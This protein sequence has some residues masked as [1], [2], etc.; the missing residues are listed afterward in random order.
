MNA[1]LYYSNTGESKRIAEHLAKQIGCEPIDITAAAD[2]EYHCA[3]LVFPVHCQNIPQKVASFLLR[4]KTKYLIVIATYGKMSYGNVL[5]EIQRRYRHNIIAAAYAPTKHAYVD[6]APFDK[7]EKLSPLLDKLTSPTTVNIPQ[8]RKNPFANLAPSWRSRQGVK[9]LLGEQCNGC[10]LCSA[11]CPEHAIK[12]GKTNNRCIRCLRCVGACPNKA[13]TFKL[14][15]PLKRY[16]K[17]P[18]TADLVIYV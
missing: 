2:C 11:I 14:A 5:N 7:F 16:L 12:N 18:K 9:I 6:E 8:T 1:V 3:L 15:P 17:K 10:G 13:L 4:L